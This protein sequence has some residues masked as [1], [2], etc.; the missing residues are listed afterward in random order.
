MRR[1]PTETREDAD[2]PTKPTKSFGQVAPVRSRAVP[3]GSVL[4]CR[5][6]AQGGH[7]ISGGGLGGWGRC[8]GGLMPRPHMAATARACRSVWAGAVVGP[9]GRPTPHVAPDGARRGP[10]KA[11]PHMVGPSPRFSEGRPHG[12]PRPF[13]GRFGAGFL[14]CFAVASKAASIARGFASCSALKR[15]YSRSAVAFAASAE[16]VPA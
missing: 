15:S 14:S 3:S 1:V 2:L 10:S 7:K 16:I 13:L 6:G 8:F 12:F 11:S 4:R 9:P 5:V